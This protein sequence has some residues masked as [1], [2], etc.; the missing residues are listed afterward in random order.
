[1]SESGFLS[2][3]SIVVP[4]RSDEDPEWLTDLIATARLECNEIV[5]VLESDA[6]V[7][8]IRPALGAFGE[9]VRFVYQ[10]GNDKSDGSEHV[11]GG[12]AAVIVQHHSIA[13]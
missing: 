6:D 1:M 2:G 3:L 8:E 5:L 4:V 10:T 7:T 12:S 11:S 9:R 13:A